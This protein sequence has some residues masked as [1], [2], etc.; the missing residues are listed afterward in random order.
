MVLCYNYYNYHYAYLYYEYCYSATLTITFP[1][2]FCAVI[3]TI[4]QHYD[5]DDDDYYYYYYKRCRFDSMS[6]AV[7][8]GSVFSCGTLRFRFGVAGFCACYR[9]IRSPCV[10]IKT[11]C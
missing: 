9:L 10:V 3:L 7:R 4:T 6:V 5:D 2:Y 1:D 11:I 8:S